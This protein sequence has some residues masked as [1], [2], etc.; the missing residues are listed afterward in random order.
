VVQAEPVPD[1]VNAEPVRKHDIP[2]QQVRSIAHHHARP[3]ELGDEL[4]QAW[5]ICVKQHVLVHLHFNLQ[6]ISGGVC[7]LGSTVLNNLVWAL[8]PLLHVLVVAARSTDGSVCVLAATAPMSPCSVLWSC[9]FAHSAPVSARCN[10]LALHVLLCIACWGAHCHGCLRSA[11]SGQPLQAL[12][13]GERG[14]G[15]SNQA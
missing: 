2:C 11:T 10:G 3:V 7:V 15:E 1:V 5:C 12:M 13:Q 9:A 6:S 14:K 8:G 4:G